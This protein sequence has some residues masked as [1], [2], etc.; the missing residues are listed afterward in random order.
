M[1]RNLLFLLLVLLVLLTSCVSKKAAVAIKYPKKALLASDE[2]Q[3]WQSFKMEGI[4]EVQF[5]MF[6]FRKNFV[7]SK[8]K[9]ALRFDLLDSGIFGFASSNISIYVDSDMQVYGYL[10]KKF[11]EI[12]DLPE[13]LRDVYTWFNNADIDDFQTYYDDLFENNSFDKDGTTFAF[14]NKMRLKEINNA[15][16]DL[17]VNIDYDYGDNISNLAI[18]LNNVKI[19]DLK[20]DKISYNNINVIKP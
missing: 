5:K 18:L 8:N 20:I 16:N 9:E 2:L 4:A 12:D 7:L 15:S 10:G 13:S 6:T 19:C 11:I 17:R 1:K 3:R 14:T